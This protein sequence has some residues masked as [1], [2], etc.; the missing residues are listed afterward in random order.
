MS[1]MFLS[2]KL[3]EDDNLRMLD[4]LNGHFGFQ[5]LPKIAIELACGKGRCTR[6]VLS[7][8]VD[9]IDVLDINPATKPELQKLKK[10]LSDREMDKYKFNHPDLPD[11]VVEDV[12]VG[13]NQ[14]VDPFE[15]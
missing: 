6:D 7:H 11:V 15:Y 5:N 9:T 1:K 3:S 2:K 4:F 13:D 12:P 10:K 8:L 14:D